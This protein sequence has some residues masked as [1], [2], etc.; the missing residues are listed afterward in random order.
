MTSGS[1][2]PVAESANRP[3]LTIEIK[4]KKKQPTSMFLID[5]PFVSDFLIKQ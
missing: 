4:S 2:K 5:K 3:A 1:M